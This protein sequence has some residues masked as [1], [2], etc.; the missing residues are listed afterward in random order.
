MIGWGVRSSVR[1]ATMRVLD[2]VE[3]L[4]EHPL[5]LSSIEITDEGGSGDLDIISVILLAERVD[6]DEHLLADPVHGGE[7]LNNCFE[8]TDGIADMH[9][10]ASIETSLQ[11]I[12]KQSVPLVKK[13]TE[14]FKLQERARDSLGINIFRKTREIPLGT[15][16]FLL[17]HSLV[18]MPTGKVP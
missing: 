8:N 12:A 3:S 9:V 2:Q 13:A 11:G 17:I 6:T 1:L 18:G 7:M 14:I 4:R 5:L 15:E 16:C 10:F